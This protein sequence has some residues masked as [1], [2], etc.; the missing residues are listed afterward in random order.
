MPI[1]DVTPITLPASIMTEADI[2]REAAQALADYDRHKAALR[3]AEITLRS[4]CRQYDLATGTRGIRD[5]HLRHACELRGL[6]PVVRLER[7][8]A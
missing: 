4:L 2:L 6:M 8:A 1:T 7:G 3:A 5:Y